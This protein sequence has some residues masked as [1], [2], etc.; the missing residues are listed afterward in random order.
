MQLVRSLDHL[1]VE[2]LFADAGL[3]AVNEQNATSVGVERK[4]DP[5]R[6]VGGA[7]PKLLH[8]GVLG[9]V[10]ANR[11]AAKPSRGPSSFSSSTVAISMERLI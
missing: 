10:V 6:L 3:V 11:R 8:V 4:R 1:L 2:P 5:Q 9:A 7:R